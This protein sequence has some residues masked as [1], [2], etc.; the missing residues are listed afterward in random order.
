[1]S[2]DLDFGVAV[3]GC[4]SATTASE[5]DVAGDLTANIQEFA[6]IILEVFLV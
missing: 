3:E 1:M 2:V 5:A 4:V 6:L